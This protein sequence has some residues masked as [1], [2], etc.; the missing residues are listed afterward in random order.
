[1]LVALAAAGCGLV[2]V[3]G[4]GI[5][6]PPMPEY[7]DTPIAQPTLVVPPVSD[8]AMERAVEVGLARSDEE[9]WRLVQRCLTPTR[10]QAEQMMEALA[11]MRRQGA[12]G[13]AVNP[14]GGVRVAGLDPRFGRARLL[15]QQGL[16]DA[17][18]VLL[19][20]VLCEYADATSKST[21][22]TE[23]VS[24]REEAGDPE[25]AVWFVEGWT[26]AD[27]ASLTSQ[28]AIARQQQA[29]LQSAQGRLGS[30]MGGAQTAE[31]GRVMRQHARDTRMRML[32]PVAISYA[33][34]GDLDRAR[35]KIAEAQ[36]LMAGGAGTGGDVEDAGHLY[37][38][39]AEAAARVGDM[40]AAQRAYAEAERRRRA[41]DRPDP[42]GASLA[43]VLA[44]LGQ[45]AEARRLAEA[46]IAEAAGW[47][48]EPRPGVER[49]AETE[50]I[51]KDMERVSN[52]LAAAAALET[53]HT[54]LAEV[55]VARG[56]GEAALRHLA[57]YDQAHAR[58]LEA[59]RATTAAMQHWAGSPPRWSR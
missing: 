17:A 47:S 55:S 24:N 21:V 8:E 44:E 36:A 7:P 34:L 54:T 14:L 40:P 26:R 12:G 48:M 38:M 19:I 13:A 18:Y 30:L 4:L 1:V 51:D 15:K 39:L 20:D 46:T 37:F 27:E 23:L 10:S 2:G 22:L 25:S 49:E 11:D 35:Q 59:Q 9:T 58:R 43:F 41:R 5:G 50:R 31:V 32:L 29:R 3:S 53:A 16:L 28:E 56:D 45:H 57:E 42:S 6:R 33:R 52:R